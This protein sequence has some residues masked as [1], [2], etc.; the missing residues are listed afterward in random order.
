MKFLVIC[1]SLVCASLPY[2]SRA[3]VLVSLNQY[4]TNPSAHI[5][6]ADE[7]EFRYQPKTVIKDWSVN[8]PY[9]YLGCGMKYQ[10][11]KLTVP[12]PGRYY[13][14]AQL[15]FRNN[16]R[17]FI[18]VNYK[19]VTMVQPPVNDKDFHGTVHAGGVFNLNANDVITLTAH[20]YPDEKGPIIYM[21]PRHSYFGAFLI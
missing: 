17:V 2:S 12:T 3:K 20:C 10:D 4:P 21:A 15:Y 19:V 18:R 1:V 5:E 7:D 16:G 11:G 9:S 13:I 14:Y 6:A 8:A